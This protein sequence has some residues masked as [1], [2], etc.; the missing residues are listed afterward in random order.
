MLANIPLFDVS[1]FHCCRW[2]E[3]PPTLIKIKV[4]N[5]QIFRIITK[6]LLLQQEVIHFPASLV[7]QSAQE[8]SGHIQA[9]LS[10]HLVRDEKRREFAFL[11]SH[12]VGD[13]GRAARRCPPRRDLAGSRLR[14][15]RTRTNEKKQV[16]VLG[17]TARH[18]PPA[19][20][21]PKYSHH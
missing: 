8:A 3:R 17:F 13:T 9:K 21:A 5:N 19:K 20:R 16:L 15:H 2:Q 12:A 18:R 1:L 4:R 11:L 14:S 7:G 10:L 6:H